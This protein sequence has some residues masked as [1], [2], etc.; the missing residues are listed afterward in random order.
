MFISVTFTETRL[1]CKMQNTE[2]SMRTSLHHVDE[3]IPFGSGSGPAPDVCIPKSD[4][5]PTS[6]L[7]TY[8]YQKAY[9]KASLHSKPP[10]STRG[11]HSD[12]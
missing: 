1:Y 5:P 3:E 7:T 11:V 2:Q 6:V 4:D 8:H 10:S 12:I 9:P